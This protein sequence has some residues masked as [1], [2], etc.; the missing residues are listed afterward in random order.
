MPLREQVRARYDSE[1]AYTD[2][3]VQRLLDALPEE[4]IIV[5]VADHGESLLEHGYVG[6]TRRIHQTTLHV[7]LLVHGPGIT[8][9]RT[10]APARGIDIAPTLL[11][12]AGLP[13]TQGMQGCDLLHAPPS[14]GRLRIVETY[15][16]DI[17]ETPEERAA[18]ASRPPMLMGALHEGWKPF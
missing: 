18:L 16:G 5:F 8:P 14:S 15:G 2:F 7:P 9:G 13:P 3:H 6:H 4:T 11:G 12:L 1:V 17:P 10:Q